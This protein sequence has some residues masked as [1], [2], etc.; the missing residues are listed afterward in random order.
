MDSEEWSTLTSC[1][2]PTTLIRDRHPISISLLASS[3]EHTI[4]V[5]NLYVA[6]KYEGRIRIDASILFAEVCT[7]GAEMSL[8]VWPYAQRPMKMF[9]T[10]GTHIYYEYLRHVGLW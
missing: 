10:F 9:L 8:A 2:P 5:P 4:N 1:E 7:G 6:D 3:P